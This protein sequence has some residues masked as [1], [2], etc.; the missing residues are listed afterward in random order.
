MNLKFLIFTLIFGLLSVHQVSASPTSPDRLIVG[1]ETF[2]LYG[3][4][5]ESYSIKYTSEMIF[6]KNR[7]FVWGCLQGYV[8]TWSIENDSLVIS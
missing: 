7:C 3:Y 2:M 1:G 6:G 5:L 8:A 4:P